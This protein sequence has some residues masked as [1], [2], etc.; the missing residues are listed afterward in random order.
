MSIVYT[1]RDYTKPLHKDILQ[2]LDSIS[3]FEFTTP[4]GQVFKMSDINRNVPVYLDKSKIRVEECEMTWK[5]LQ[6]TIDKLEREHQ[7]LKQ[8]KYRSKEET[9]RFEYL[10]GLIRQL[11]EAAESYRKDHPHPYPNDIVTINQETA[12]NGY[13]TRNGKSHNPEIVLLMETLGNY[14]WNTESVAIT[15]VHEMFHAFYDCDLSKTCKSLPY[16][17]EPLTEYAMLKFMEAFVAQNNEYNYLLARA[18]HHVFRKQ[19]SCGIA[20]Y[21]FGHYLWKYEKESGKTPEDIHWI[22]AFREAKY[23]IWHNS[24]EYIEYAKP[25]KQG[26]Y[27]FDEEEY[28]MDLLRVILYNANVCLP[29]PQKRQANHH[30]GT[31][32]WEKIGTN[33]HLAVENDILYLDGDYTKHFIWELHHNNSYEEHRYNSRGERLLDIREII[34]AKIHNHPIKRIVLW[35]RFIC[36]EFWL[37]KHITFDT[38]A[39]VE[40]SGRNPYFTLIN[41]CIYDAKMTI[42]LYC[43]EDATE[44]I[45][46]EDVRE[47]NWYAFQHCT[48]LQHIEIPSSV[49]SIDKESFSDCKS[50][51]DEIIIGQKLFNVPKT[52]TCYAIPKGVKEISYTAFYHCDSLQ[53]V[54]IPP[55]LKNQHVSFWLCKNLED[56]IIFGSTLVHV[57]ATAITYEIPSSV[58]KIGGDAFDHCVNLRSVMIPGGIKEIPNHTF[59]KCNNI[60]SVLFGEGIEDIGIWA[61]D[62]CQLSDVTL[63]ASLKEIH[64]WAFSE[65]PMQTLTFKG[66]NPP[67]TD[68]PFDNKHFRATCII[69]VPAGSK[70]DYAKIFPDHT[71]VEY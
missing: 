51:E 55:S 25:F 32:P 16:V 54:E 7:Y 41:G 23:K 48:S 10:F 52:A 34:Y 46:P 42:L 21:S 20:H 13:Y 12:L 19:F 71:I 27:P 56:E 26:L 17:E 50:L 40:L 36:D 33:T 44:C 61:F 8:K 14:T 43:P 38:H 66:A 22:D 57:P 24:Q 31:L 69:R 11:K 53:H 1:P 35:D 67:K 6:S 28:Q 62:G 39:C 60:E 70:S 5:E 68:E 30:G 63:P 18:Q 29:L 65:C 59:K 58:K 45:I 64:R 9:D 15:L 2:L 4:D 37:I 49:N 3:D 47:L